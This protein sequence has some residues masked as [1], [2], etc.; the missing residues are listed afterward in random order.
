MSEFEK[1]Y[2]EHVDAVFRYAV[3]CV[4][5]RDIAEDIASEAFL[6]LYQNRDRIDTSQ[7]PGWLL[8]VARNRATDYWRHQAVEQRYA[9]ILAR[10]PA[11]PDPPGDDRLLD[12]EELKPVHRACLMFRY[13]HGMTRTEIAERT[14]LSPDQVKE[15]LRYGL[16]VLRDQL[17]PESSRG[18]R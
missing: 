1:L 6:A 11:P 12:N 2:T 14:G 4:G 3:S 8:R 7:L 10:R 17:V 16:R 9:S 13:V 15:R 5:R 18:L